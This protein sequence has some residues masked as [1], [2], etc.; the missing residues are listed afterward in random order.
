MKWKATCGCYP[1]RFTESYRPS[2]IEVL[3]SVD[4]RSTVIMHARMRWSLFKTS[5]RFIGTHMV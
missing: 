3:E 2:G 1:L 5:L 4:H